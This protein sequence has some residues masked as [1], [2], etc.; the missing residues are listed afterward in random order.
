MVHLGGG[1]LLL[2][3]EQEFIGPG[4]LGLLKLDG[5]GIA[6]GHTTT[7]SNEP[8]GGWIASMHYYNGTDAGKPYLRLMHMKSQDGWPVLAPI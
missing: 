6:T 2:K 8:P 1:T 4:Q 7:A 5:G 3:M